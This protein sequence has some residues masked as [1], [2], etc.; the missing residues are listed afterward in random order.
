MTDI[1]VDR[2]DGGAKGQ[3]VCSEARRILDRLFRLD[4]RNVQNECNRV[5]DLYRERWSAKNPNDFMVEYNLEHTK[6]AGGIGELDPPFLLTAPLTVHIHV[7]DCLYPSNRETPAITVVNS[8]DPKNP[9]LM[10]FLP[11][12]QVTNSTITLTHF[13]ASFKSVIIHEFLHLCGDIES[14]T[15]PIVD[16]VIR[17]TKVDTEAIEPLI[18]D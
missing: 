8:A 17:H 10:I 15:S 18:G 9:N 7:Y 3:T 14:P 11:T 6:Y 12:L 13:K 5:A 16:G 2:I 1:Y 4:L